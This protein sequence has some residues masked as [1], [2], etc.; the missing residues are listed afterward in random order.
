MC[1]CAHEA[2]LAAA[3]DAALDEG[4]AANGHLGI[5]GDA[6][7]LSVLKVSV[8]LV[9][10]FIAFPR[11]SAVVLVITS[12]PRCASINIRQD[13]LACAKDVAFVIGFMRRGVVHHH[14]VGAYFGIVPDDDRT[15][16]TANQPIRHSHFH[17]MFSR[18]FLGRGNIVS[19]D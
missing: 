7:R 12:R 15:L 11:I 2:V 10:T 9:I 5:V 4:V 16:S 1:V 19:A 18:Y 3:I 6:Q 8:L 14:V 13:T 17:A